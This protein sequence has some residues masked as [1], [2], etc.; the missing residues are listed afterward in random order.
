MAKIAK[1]IITLSTEGKGAYGVTTE[2]DESVYIPVS[3]AEALELEEFEQVEA[4]VVKND[5]KDP[6]WR[7]IRVRR[8][9][10]VD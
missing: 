3:V 5:R 1:C 6:V 8:E 10:D 7:A 4:I 9:D 2:D